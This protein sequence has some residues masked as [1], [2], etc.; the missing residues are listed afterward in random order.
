MPVVAFLS[1]ENLPH[2]AIDDELAAAALRAAGWK[3]WTIPWND[4]AIDWGDFSAA[5][6]RSTWDYQEKPD[7]F[8]TAL[9]RITQAGARLAN[10][11]EI[12]RW[13]MHKSYLLDLQARGLPVVPTVILPELTPSGLDSLINTLGSDEI[14]LKPAI[15][16][17]A[18][19]TFRLQRTPGSAQIADLTARFKGRAVLGQPFMPHIL[20][21]GEYSLFFFLGRYSHAAI[22]TPA[23]GDFRVQE[24]HGGLTRP[25][26][27]PPAALDVARASLMQVTPAPLYARVDLVRTTA[28]QFALMELEL[29]EPVLY[30]QL[31]P[32]APQRFVRAFFDWIE[33]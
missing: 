20:A 1:M 25:A 15:S 12:V 5:V 2:P 30:F 27:P 22:K 10:P 6:I 18:L 11:L 26:E 14:I 7:Q 28:G 31:D 23:R 24:E 3:V 17:S 32:A 4:P 8:L 21:E 19:D 29:I 13:N 9:E 33:K 16:A